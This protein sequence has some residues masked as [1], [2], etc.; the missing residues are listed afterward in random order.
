MNQV[1]AGLCA[2][3]VVAGLLLL[4]DG[5]RPRPREFSTGSS[6]QLWRSLGERWTKRSRSWRIRA[7]LAAAGA[8]VLFLVTG[9][10][11]MLIATPALVM[12][13]PAL[14]A[15]PPNR[16]IEVLEALDRWV[17]SLVSSLPTGKSITDAI[18]ATAP[19]APATI[20]T[21]VQLVVARLEARWTTRE[22][23]LALADD[24]DSPDAD[25][26]IAA[27]VLAAQR[28]G[29]GAAATLAGLADSIQARLRALREI[30]SE[31]SK[32]RIVV[33]QVTVISIVALAVA[34]VASPDFFAPYGSPIGQLM[35][36]LLLAGYVGSL[37]A[38]RRVTRPRHRERILSRPGTAEVGHA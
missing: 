5:I 9:W 15:D 28:G 4:V 11:V 13:L 22:A 23:L 27:L 29:Q 21:P 6:T 10:P 8:V 30:E 24:L 35:V 34:V 19:Q 2:A 38:M 33:R 16:D 18:R 26:V 17:R 1:V 7:G 25:A 14:L 37:L 36:C 31:R 3:A 32:P 12:G 20:R